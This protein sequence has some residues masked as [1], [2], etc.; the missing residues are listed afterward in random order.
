MIRTKTFK[1]MLNHPDRYAT[2]ESNVPAQLLRQLMAMMAITPIEWETKLDA[3]FKDLHGDDLKKIREEKSNLT[4][5]LEKDTIS[6][7]RFEQ[8]INVLGPVRYKFSLSL[9][10]KNEYSV[11]AKT[12]VRTRSSR[13][14]MRRNEIDEQS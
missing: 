1:D 12:T 8:A 5:A 2:N 9:E 11:E 14:L 10:F 7:N 4:G 13:R 3:Y 6:W